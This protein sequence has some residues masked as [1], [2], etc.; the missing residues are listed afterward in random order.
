MCFFLFWNAVNIWVLDIWARSA[1]LSWVRFVSRRSWV[2]IPLLVRTF[3]F[4]IPGSRSSLVDKV[5][6][7]EIN[8][9]ILWVYTLYISVL[10]KSSLEKNM[11]AISSGKS[12]FISAL[13][14]CNTIANKGYTI[15]RHVSCWTRTNVFTYRKD[16]LTCRQHSASSCDTNK[17][18]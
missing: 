12:L 15:T 1:T 10:D 13:S 17:V 5:Y 18:V 4:V 7:N 9:D 14:P 6:A 8:H 2:R 11:A 16:V 3:H